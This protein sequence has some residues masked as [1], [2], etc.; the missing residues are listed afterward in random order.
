MNRPKMYNCLF[1]QLSFFNLHLTHFTTCIQH[2]LKGS[3]VYAPCVVLSTFH[4]SLST[5]ACTLL[6]LYFLSFAFSFFTQ[7][8]HRY[9]TVTFCRELLLSPKKTSIIHENVTRKLK[10]G[11][12]Y[13]MYS[14]LFITFYAHVTFVQKLH[15]STNIRFFAVKSMLP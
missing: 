10:N 15:S 1:V 8:A 4:D 14:L 2:S 12:H 9:C 13:H 6:T 3:C 11:T 7:S 5:T